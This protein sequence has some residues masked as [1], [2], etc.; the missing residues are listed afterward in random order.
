M[1][2]VAMLT[3]RPGL[4][5]EKMQESLPRRALWQAPANLKILGEYVLL[6]EGPGRPHVIAIGETEDIA[7]V[8]RM[9]TSWNDLFDVSIT[10]AVSVEQAYQLS[11]QLGGG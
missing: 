8:F 2:F 11:Q 9:Y 7:A 3:Y 5:A 10:P 1:L 4:P 6:G